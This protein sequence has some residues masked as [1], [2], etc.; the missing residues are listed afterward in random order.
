MGFRA[1]DFPETE[2]AYES[3]LSIP[4]FPDLTENQQDQVVKVLESVV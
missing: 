4:I 2:R 1:E 3:L